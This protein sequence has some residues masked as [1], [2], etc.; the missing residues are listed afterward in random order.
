MVL[1]IHL[2]ALYYGRPEPISHILSER[3]DLFIE[4]G[5]GEAKRARFHY[6]PRAPN[7]D[8]KKFFFF[9]QPIWR[10][11]LAG[12]IKRSNSYEDPHLCLIV[13]SIVFLMQESHFYVQPSPCWLSLAPRSTSM[14]AK[15]TAEIIPDTCPSQHKMTPLQGLGRM[16]MVRR[17]T[18]AHPNRRC[19]LVKYLLDATSLLE[20]PS[21]RWRHLSLLL[22]RSFGSLADLMRTKTHIN[23]LLL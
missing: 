12:L 13:Y 7:R 20:T 15:T 18:W 16:R 21:R 17:T 3:T 23:S 8:K 14:S 9:S 11:T 2:A 5:G 1:Q 10:L 22:S 19:I 6:D 4:Q